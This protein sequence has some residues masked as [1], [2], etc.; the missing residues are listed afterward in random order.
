MDILKQNIYINSNVGANT[1]TDYQGE[2]EKIK[3]IKD[4]G[5]IPDMMMD[6]SLVKLDVP[7][8]RIVQDTLNIHVGTVLS[9]IP[10]TKQDGLQWQRCKEY[11]IQL[12]EDG[13]SFVTIHFTAN[14]GLL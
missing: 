10:F 4:S 13:V 2:I 1:I 14:L 6:L 9:Y 7:L 11:L 12:G 5:D 3:A 8:Y